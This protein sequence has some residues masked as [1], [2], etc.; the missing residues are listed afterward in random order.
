MCQ[1]AK[2]TNLPLIQVIVVNVHT[3]LLKALV[4]LSPCESTLAKKRNTMS[5]HVKNPCNV[6]MHCETL[7][8]GAFRWLGDIMGAAIQF[9]C[10]VLFCCFVYEIVYCPKSS[11]ARMFSRLIV[12]HSGFSPEVI[13]AASEG[14]R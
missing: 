2:P 12:K 13:L 10:H 1:L 5:V 9:V 3:N 8:L 11:V 7:P 14:V 6:T 4:D